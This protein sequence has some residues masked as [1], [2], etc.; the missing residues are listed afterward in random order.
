MP[1]SKID[2]QKKPRKF[3]SSHESSQ[4]QYWKKLQQEFE[5]LK[6]DLGCSEVE[7]AEGLGI[8]RQSLASFMKEKYDNKSIKKGLSIQRADLLNLWDYLLDPENYKNRKVSQADREKRRVLKQKKQSADFLL[9][10]AGFLPESG[11]FY[12]DSELHPSIQRII[13]KLRIF[14]VHVLKNI[15]PSQAYKLV[16]DLSS[17]IEELI[18]NKAFSRVFAEDRKELT[19]QDIETGK[20]LPVVFSSADPVSLQKYQKLLKKLIFLGK[21]YFSNSELFELYSTIYENSVST[22]NE[23]MGVRVVQSSF[24]TL[25]FSISQ[26]LHSEEFSK[27]LNSESIQDIDRQVS[28]IAIQVE[29]NIKNISGIDPYWIQPLVKATVCCTASFKKGIEQTVSLQLSHSSDSTHF[30]N[31]LSALEVGFSYQNRLL[32][33]NSSSNAIGEHN[34]SL[35]KTF[36]VYEDQ[37]TSRYYQGA[38]IDES[39]TIG[40]IQACLMAY[41]SWIDEQI[42]THEEIECYLEICKLF[43]D[44]ENHIENSRRALNRYL[45]QS[46]TYDEQL[47]HKPYAFT[48][49]LSVKRVA[50]SYI[51]IALSKAKKINKALRAQDTFTSSC[52]SSLLEDR[53]GLIYLLDARLNHIQGNLKAAEKSLSNIKIENISSSTQRL[54]DAEEIINNFFSGNLDGL[55]NKFYDEYDQV[56]K[57]VKSQDSKN[58]G[59][60]FDDYLSLAEIHGNIGR[61]NFYYCN[62]TLG[63]DAKTIENYV[64]SEFI[65][66]A[67][68]SSRIGQKQRVNHWLT[69]ISRA[70]VRLDDKDKADS[71]IQLAELILHDSIEPRYSLKFKESIFAES[72]LARGEILLLSGNYELAIHNFVKALK[73]SINIGFA[74]IISDS[75]YGISRAASP[76]DNRTPKLDFQ[77]TNIDEALKIS[78]KRSLITN[79]VVDF[80][81]SIN[82]EERWCSYTESFKSQAMQIWNGW[83]STRFSSGDTHFIANMMDNNQLLSRLQ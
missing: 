24:E 6:K 13:S 50:D 78:N 31:M 49:G 40:Y 74:R 29:E 61:L 42:T 14:N 57:V 16:E 44:I 18:W 73:G 51:S 45:F 54:F 5:K 79:R 17:S 62:K 12:V 38:W 70:Y 43:N 1:A 7:I 35:V 36:V 67:Y 81:N 63:H 34:D 64:I 32:L 30:E 52:F 23:L 33:V 47:N 72:N 21:K 9:T 53:E 28:D 60:S 11:V 19:V 15:A 26:Y 20:N 10:S 59:S 58:P 75:L 22:N 56:F 69:H 39:L 65:K 37:K 3:T 55:R 2:D 76:L 68:L 8:S 83:Y 66:A 48:D 41:K 80:L 82:R 27:S 25:S 71:Y 4:K 46:S 77:D